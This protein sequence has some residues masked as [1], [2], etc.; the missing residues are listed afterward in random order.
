MAQHNSSRA[1]LL[2]VWRS[3]KHGH[4]HGPFLVL[5]THSKHANTK[6]DIWKLVT[7]N[8]HG[9][10]PI[11]DNTTVRKK[12]TDVTQSDGRAPRH[13]SL[14]CYQ[15]SFA[16]KM[17]N[18]YSNIMVPQIGYIN[19]CDGYCYFPIQNHLTP[20][21]HAIIWAIWWKRHSSDTYTPKRPLCIPSKLGT[22]TVIL[23]DPETGQP[24]QK[25]WQEFSAEECGCR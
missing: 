10:S 11:P 6:D 7:L 9:L 8:P 15:V 20:T 18:F 4:L 1:S 13:P 17:N 21:T 24:V 5:Y 12:N 19:Y 3:I 14:T 2:H 25:E 22:V 16:I 23:S